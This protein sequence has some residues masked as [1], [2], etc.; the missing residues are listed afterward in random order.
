MGQG[1]DMPG[2]PRVDVGRKRVLLANIGGP[3]QSILQQEPDLD[4]RSCAAKRLANLL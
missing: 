3:G 1:I 2:K 4:M